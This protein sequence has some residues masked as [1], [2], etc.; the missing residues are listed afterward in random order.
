KKG[1][2]SITMR[3]EEG[4]QYKVNDLKVSGITRPD[5]GT[6]LSLLA[7]SPGQPYSD[8]GVAADRDY[9]LNIY[10]STGYPDATFEAKVTPVEGANE[11]TV[12]YTVKEGAPLYVRDVLITGLHATSGRLV[13]P[14][15]LLKAGDPLSWTEMGR[16]QRRLYN[17]GVFDKVDMAIQNP[18]GDVQN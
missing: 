10:Q 17:L 15:I 16:M 4:P 5:Q 9:I 8:T 13:N 3:V 12:E 2:V 6:I 11:V 18:E 1:S 7:L 14:N